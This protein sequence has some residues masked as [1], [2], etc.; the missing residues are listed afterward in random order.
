MIVVMVVCC[1]ALA[2]AQLTATQ[3]DALMALY[4]ALR[5]IIAGGS[6]SSRRLDTECNSS[7]CTRFPSSA[8]CSINRVSSQYLTCAGGFVTHLFVIG[9]YCFVCFRRVRST[10]RLIKGIFIL[11]N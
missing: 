4:T 7:V 1:V 5:K 8:P 11:H 2:L 3:Y 6:R 9:F 10:Y